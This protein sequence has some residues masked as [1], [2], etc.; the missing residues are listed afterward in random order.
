VAVVA[1][2]L[3]LGLF[4]L[5]NGSLIEGIAVYAVA[6]AVM[7]WLARRTSSEPA[8]DSSYPPLCHRQR[9]FGE[10]PTARESYRLVERRRSRLQAWEVSVHDAA[11]FDGDC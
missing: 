9:D 2:A 10:T 3:V 5:T 11:I 1:T 6:G 4:L 8:A 7:R